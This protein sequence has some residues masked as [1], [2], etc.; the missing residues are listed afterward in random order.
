MDILIDFDTFAKRSD[1]EIAL[2]VWDNT[3]SEPWCELI[4][5][6]QFKSEAE[7]VIEDTCA[8][9]GV[10]THDMSARAFQLTL[11]DYEWFEQYDQFTEDLIPE[12]VETRSYEIG[13]MLY[14]IE[15]TKLHFV[16]R[17]N[18]L[19]DSV[20]VAFSS[21]L[22]L[23]AKQI[24]KFKKDFYS[25]NKTVGSSKFNEFANH[26]LKTAECFNGSD[27]DLAQTLKLVS[28]D[29]NPN[30]LIEVMY[31]YT[32][33]AKTISSKSL[34]RCVR[35]F[36]SVKTSISELEHIRE[37]E[38]TQLQEVKASRKTL[39]KSLTEQ[40]LDDVLSFD[41]QQEGRELKEWILERL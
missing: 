7:K 11:I 41:K 23:N 33:I 2:T 40:Q 35:A 5:R 39:L 8:Q 36:D 38:N 28:S 13:F 29:S 25:P 27:V 6:S 14:K 30:K 34:Q 9:I 21:V 17:S 26:L 24:S 15:D 32:D 10:N 12:S 4:S 20:V 1:D 3:E 16:V 31:S 37:M 18:V 22:H 19:R